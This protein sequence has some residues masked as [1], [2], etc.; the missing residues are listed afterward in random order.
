MR[1]SDGAQIL[2]ILVVI[3]FVILFKGGIGYLIGTRKGKGGLGF[4][5]GLFLGIIGWIIIAVIPG[6]SPAMMPVRRCR[7]CGRPIP[8]GQL[9]C[10]RCR[11]K[12]EADRVPCPLCAELILP[13]ARICRYCHNKLGA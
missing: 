10:P 1:S 11:P 3:A 7:D 9:A 5:L 12:R 2:V 13:G 8:R 6:D 4:V